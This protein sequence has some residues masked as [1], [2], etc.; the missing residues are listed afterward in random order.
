MGSATLPT[1][2]CIPGSCLSIE[3]YWPKFHRTI[4][5]A[6]RHKILDVFPS[7]WMRLDPD[8]SIAAGKLAAELGPVGYYA[9]AFLD[10]QPVAGAGVLP[11]RGKDYVLGNAIKQTAVQ[12]AGGPVHMPG[13]ANSGAGEPRAVKDW[14]LCCVATDPKHRGRGLA[15]HVVTRLEELIRE[16]GARSLTTR[17]IE[18]ESGPFWRK[19]GFQTQAGAG[20]LL[21]KGFRN[22]SRPEGE[23]LK[24]DIHFTMGVK[25]LS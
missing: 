9:V 8:P 24:N 10:G 12:E 25:V 7:S 2:K 21:P 6:Y 3:P 19:L 23:A 14:E 5:D 20:G 16:K 11:F 15:A 18:E 22:D 13:P 1:T 4:I 17:Y